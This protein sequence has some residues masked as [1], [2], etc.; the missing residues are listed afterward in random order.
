M[1]IGALRFIDLAN[2]RLWLVLSNALD[3]SKKAEKTG[4]FCLHNKTQSV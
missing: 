3:A 1:H 4:V 2:S